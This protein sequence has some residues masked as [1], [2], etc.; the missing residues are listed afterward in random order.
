MKD[1]LKI[2]K[3]RLLDYYRAG[4]LFHQKKGTTLASSSSFYALISIVPFCL[5]LV[6]G[7]G[8]FLGNLDKTQ[9]YIFILGAEFFPEIAPQLLIKLQT[10]IKGPLFAG[11]KFTLLNFFFLGVSA[12]SFLNSIWTGVFFITND[13]SVI[14]PWRILRGVVIIALTF[15]MLSLVFILPPIIIF[16]IKFIQ[17][18]VLTTFLWD[19]FEFLRPWLQYILKINLK[20][21]YWL[22]SDFLHISVLIIYF[23]I[24]YRWIFSWR[25]ELNEAF[26]AALAFTFSVFLGKSFFWIYIYYVR[27]SMARNYGDLYTSVIG[28]IWLFLLMCFF[29]YGACVCRVFQE[30]RELENHQWP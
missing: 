19:N 15:L 24:L 11:T 22:D 27:A 13:K 21:S 14:S 8:Y 20:R 17:S 2:L 3:S 30:K 29:F 7:I 10:M 12:F 9:K 4:L 26:Q 5:L 6:R 1:A 16:I 18:N 28:V 25:I 23:T